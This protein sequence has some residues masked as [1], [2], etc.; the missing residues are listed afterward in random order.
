M[1][2]V[3]HNKQT[4]IR[5]M[6][7]W[8][9]FPLGAVYFIYL[10]VGL[11]ISLSLSL[12]WVGLPLLLLTL[13]GVWS[14]AMLERYLL[15]HWLGLELRPML[16][17]V[18]GSSGLAERVRAFLRN[19][20]TWKIVVYLF[21]KSAFGIFAVLWNV[22]CYGIVGIFGLAP[23]F[24]LVLVYNRIYDGVVLWVSFDGSFNLLAFLSLFLACPVALLLGMGALVVSN[25]IVGL[26][27]RFAQTMLG[28]SVLALKL[29]ESLQVAERESARASSADQSRREL[30]VNVSH[31]LRTPIAIISGHVESLMMALET[32][33]DQHPTDQQP[34][35]LPLPLTAEQ[36]QS[37]LG[38]V[39][40]EVERLGAL[41]DDLLMLAR[42]DADEL[43][44]EVGPVEAGELLEDVYQTLQ[45]LAWREREIS[46]VCNVPPN[47]PPV[48][49]DRQRLMQVVLNLVR[50]A[51]AYT[52]PGGIVALSLTQLDAYHLRL[53]IADTGVGISEEDQS[54]IFE[55]FYRTD[56]SRVRTSGGFGL[57]LAIVRDLVRA[58]GGT[59]AVE[60][61]VGEGSCFYVTLPI[62]RAPLGSSPSPTPSPQIATANQKANTPH[63]E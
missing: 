63:Y 18:A 61:R 23:L 43:H 54:R 37:Y 10:V 7:L 5:Q 6:Y 16:R 60:S 1:L 32:P 35:S 12:V 22:I 62:A 4:F 17:P 59:V 25:E 45:P 44:I 31:D 24:Y 14:L 3:L 26:W 42:A 49:A 21:S 48:L 13:T 38:I 8:L 40:T 55:R 27:G 56:A 58:M 9:S 11:G 29:Q 47:L 52:P 19:G 57:G 53:N 41:V 28:E 20:L 15:A 39:N 34:H 51:I 2:A 30:I 50:N 46:M 36:L 33:A